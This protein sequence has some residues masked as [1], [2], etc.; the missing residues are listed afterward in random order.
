MDK[1]RRRF[2]NEEIQAILKE[3]ERAATIKDLCDKYGIAKQTLY[4]WKKEFGHEGMSSQRRVKQLEAENIEL[5]RLLG[6]KEL[7]L[8]RALE[9]RRDKRRGS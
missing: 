1:P 9:K 6:E 8:R 4:R 7:E 3:A 2:T 5:K